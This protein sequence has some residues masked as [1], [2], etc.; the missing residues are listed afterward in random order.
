MKKL[1][2][3]LTLLGTLAS[4]D[5]CCYRG[6]Y[7]HDHGYIG[8]NWIAP[9]VVGGVLGYEL[10]RP[11]EVIIEQQPVYVRPPVVVDQMPFTPNAPFPPVGYHYVTIQ[12]PTCNCYK[13]ALMPN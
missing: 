8:N 1:I 9:A 11:R 13:L 4:A 6:E 12:D 2:L 7:R 5:A 3:S 10:A